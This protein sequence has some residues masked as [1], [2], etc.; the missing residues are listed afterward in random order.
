MPEGSADL[1]LRARL[2]LLRSSLTTVQRALAD[3]ESCRGGPTGVGGPA[4]AASLAAKVS[5]TSTALRKELAGVEMDV[6]AR[7]RLDDL[8]NELERAANSAAPVSSA[9]LLVLENTSVEEDFRDDVATQLKALDALDAEVDAAVVAQPP[10]DDERLAAAWL[11][12]QALRDECQK[13]FAEYVDL[14]R[15]VLLRD[16]VFDRDLCR[17]ADELV[18]QFGK[19][20]DYTWQAFTIPASR[21]RG[22][23]TSARLIRIGFPEWTVWTLP[24]T[25]HEFGHVFAARHEA[26]RA[27]VATM[28]AQEPAAVVRTQ[29]ADAFATAVMG[30]AYVW[31]A[32]LL[33]VDP[34][35]ELDRLRVAVMLAMFDRLEVTPLSTYGDEVAALRSRWA[36]AL[37]QR[38]DD[39]AVAAD[40]AE[41]VQTIVGDVHD[42]VRSPFDSV[43]WDRALAVVD[44]LTDPVTA[45]EAIA[46]QLV[47]TGLGDLRHLF[48]AGWVARVRIE[49]V[50]PASQGEAAAQREQVA[51]L[52][53]RVRMVG[54]AVVDRAGDWTRYRPGGAAVQ[55]REV[56]RKSDD[57]E[58]TP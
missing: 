41:H 24:L 48:A 35:Q 27:L 29:I 19:F 40:V 49:G 2:G 39:A 23:L 42:R 53:E 50:R 11:R 34:G 17:I 36:S 10:D 54:K 14:V 28:S 26:M 44:L 52:T 18:R 1:V 45:A 8:V 43:E 16:A 37:H 6:E 3:L 7:G 12:Y 58:K 33:R 20:K 25:A 15:G 46:D 38:G 9:P 57:N 56:G 55:R 32:L 4:G 30:P 13:L 31:S 51:E 5:Q 22:D 21:E 47:P